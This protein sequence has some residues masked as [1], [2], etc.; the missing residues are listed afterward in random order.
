MSNENVAHFSSGKIEVFVKK[1]TKDFFSLSS[2]FFKM[3]RFEEKKPGEK[4]QFK[5]ILIHPKI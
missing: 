3:N 4:E 5:N 2:R 1:T